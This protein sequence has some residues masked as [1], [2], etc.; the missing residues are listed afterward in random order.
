MNRMTDM[1]LKTRLRSCL[2]TILELEP[3]LVQTEVGPKMQKEFD[4]LKRF[5][6]ELE[7]L[8]LTEEDVERVEISTNIFLE[9]ISLP[10]QCGACA[11][12]SSTTLSRL[13]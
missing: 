3:C 6:L 11:M 12:A 4:A 5:L 7:H 9:E 10:I 2:Q 13:Q 1:L 8:S